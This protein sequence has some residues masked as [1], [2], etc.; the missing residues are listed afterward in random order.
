MRWLRSC[1]KWQARQTNNIGFKRGPDAHLH[2][3]LG[4]WDSY[5]N[6]NEASSTCAYL[7]LVPWVFAERGSYLSVRVL[8]GRRVGH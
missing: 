2:P 4:R 1:S 7:V 8:W 5:Q 3:K 6:H